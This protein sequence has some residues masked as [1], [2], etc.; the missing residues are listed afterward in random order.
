MD[1]MVEAM[2]CARVCVVMGY[3]GGGSGGWMCALW[4]WLFGLLPGLGRD[5]QL[6]A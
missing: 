2:V 4:R 5:R 3:V 6:L 1:G